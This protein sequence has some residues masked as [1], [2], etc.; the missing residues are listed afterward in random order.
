MAGRG[1]T[2]DFNANVAR[3]TSSVDKMSNDLS[4]FQTNAERTSKNIDKSFARLGMGIKGAFGGLAAALSIRELGQMA[5]SF[6]NIQARL[7]LATKDANEFA[8]ANENIRRI[9]D[10]SKSPLQETAT[11]YTRISQSLIDVGGTQRQVADVTQA[12]ALS[13]RL[14]GAT[15]EESASAMLQF[16]QA[17]GSG[18]LRGE[19]FNA[20]NEAAPRAMKALAD[21]LGVPIGQL[22]N[23]AQE[24]EITRDILVDALGSQLPQLL[25]EAET[26]PN[27][28][29]ASLTDLSNKLL[30][31]IGQLDKL[32]GASGKAAN[33]IG[34]VGSGALKGIAILGSNVAFVFGDVYR[35]LGGIGE[36]LAALAKGDFHGLDKIGQRL[37]L[38]TAAARRELK[39]FQD[40]L[41]R[42]AA[43]AQIAD[44]GGATKPPGRIKFGNDQ[45]VNSA[46]KAADEREKI[47]QHEID[48]ELEIFSKYHKDRER[49]AGE[50]QQALDSLMKE[51]RSLQLSVDPMARMNAEVERY[52]ELLKAGAIDQKTFDMAVADSAADM[53]RAMKNSLDSLKSSAQGA[54]DHLNAVLIGFQTNVQR[55]MGD[56]VFRT[57][58]GDFQSI[59][60]AWKTM[61]LRMASDAIA[62]NLANSIFGGGGKGGLLKTG[63]SVLGSVMG[64][65]GSGGS[66]F[67]GFLKSTSGILN[68]TSGGPMGYAAKGA[69]FDDNVA[70][71][72]LGGIV[73]SP[74]PFKFSSGGALHNGL[75]GEAG[76]EAIMPLSRDSKGRLGVTGGGGGR[77]V[78]IT[79]NINIDSR[80]DKSEV[81]AIVSRAVRQGNAELVDKLS[82]QGAI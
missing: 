51:G 5:D 38:E 25:K 60:D 48:V 53:E 59:G 3:F 57:L 70:K 64:L 29:G 62:A 47:F 2:V 23:L 61:L 32:T 24:G 52:S 36:R 50:S 66:S 80:T 35:E 39:E 49:L 6:S 41:T 10:S 71:F 74:T 56:T 31:T 21:A 17:I 42:P 26:L 78:V 34:D 79:Q 13:L 12:L 58:S 55:N 72:A 15:A 73:N 11:L 14:S 82:R 7:K 37:R 27:T 28:I 67:G 76:P 4:K 46:K 43:V 54:Q 65:F 77:N 81:H 30:L 18:V 22:R 40:Q 16:S 9:A 45:S 63:L 8:L 20:V 75:M 69:Y 19:E 68:V 1:V 44:D 33:L